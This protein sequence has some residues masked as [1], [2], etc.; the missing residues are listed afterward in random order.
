MIHLTKQQKARGGMEMTQIGRELL[1]QLTSETESGPFVTVMLN[2]HVSHQEVEKDQIKL[3]NFAKE[4]RKRFEKKY[5]EASWEPYQYQMEQL[6][7]SQPFWRTA[8]TSVALIF[9]QEKTFIHRLSIRVDDQYYVGDEPYLLAIIKNSQ[10]NYDYFLLALNRD[11][12]SLYESKNHTLAP[13]A[14]PA[15]AP[16]TLKQALGDEIDKKASLSHSSSEGNTFH[17][18]VD[19]NEEEEIDHKNYYQAVDAFFREE[20]QNERRLPLF[21]MGLAENL[22]LFEKLAKNAY[23]RRDIQIK[24]SPNQLT[25]EE[26]QSVSQSMDAQLSEQEKK[27]YQKLA[28]R[29]WMEQLADIKQSA[30]LGRISDLFISTENLIDGFGENPEAEYDWRQVL[31]HLANEVIRMNGNVYLLETTDIPMNKKI[32][33]IL[34]Y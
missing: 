9:T 22:T 21:A 32:L 7:A 18:T 31:N 2:T 14:L 19:K 27:S 29:K 34:R 10:F 26:L 3:K 8:T 24:R 16:I 30:P 23:L 15:T 28:N 17:S 6:L 5:P 4:A 33:A 20:W 25:R 12:F 11:S 13:I 1:V